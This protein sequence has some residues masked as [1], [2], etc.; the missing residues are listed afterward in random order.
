MVRCD[1]PKY[2]KGVGWICGQGGGREGKVGC[3]SRDRAYFQPME[4]WY[5]LV[6]RLMMDK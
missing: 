1:N 5:G 4:R 6:L 3:G 2:C